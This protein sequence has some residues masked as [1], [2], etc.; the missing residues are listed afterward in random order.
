MGA[1]NT[2]QLLGT[3]DPCLISRSFRE[4]SMESSQWMNQLCEDHNGVLADGA[5]SSHHQLPIANTNPRYQK[6]LVLPAAGGG[7]HTPI[8]RC[9]CFKETRKFLRNFDVQ[10]LAKDRLN[11]TCQRRAKI[12]FS[13]TTGQVSNSN[14]YLFPRFHDAPSTEMVISRILIAQQILSRQVLWVATGNE[15]KLISSDQRAKA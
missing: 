9:E 7:T 3:D 14:S 13:F 6:V 1:T 4:G 8:G 10:Q 15:T 11:G 12:C 2:R 5:L